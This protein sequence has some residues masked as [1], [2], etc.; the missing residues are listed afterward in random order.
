MVQTDEERMVIRQ[1]EVHYIQ[2]FLEILCTLIGEIKSEFCWVVG[3]LTERLLEFL[4]HKI[5]FC[6]GV[7]CLKSE[8]LSGIIVKE[9]KFEQ[10]E[11]KSLCL[12]VI[13]INCG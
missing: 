8:S 12:L 6:Q 3:K 7:L 10:W 4:A 13:V 9:F 1:A 2:S 11:Q 5:Y